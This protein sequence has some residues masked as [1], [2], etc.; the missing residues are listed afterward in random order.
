[1]SR[2][3]SPCPPRAYLLRG[4][5]G[6]VI[7]NENG[8]GATGNNS[9]VAYLGLRVKMRPSMFRRLARRLSGEQRRVGS[10]SYL[11]EQMA[12]GRGIGA[13]TLYLRIPD[14]WQAGDLSL[15]ASIASHEGRH[16]ML[17]AAEL[18][19]DEP[20]ETHVLP[21][22]YRRRHLTPQW[23]QRIQSGVISED[24]EYIPGPL[25]TSYL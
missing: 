16:R 14:D 2:R 5:S 19:G 25:F 24:G 1:M 21:V 15:P 7:D 12:A 10:S 4:L 11:R 13:P 22:H 3:C 18:F 9:N 8:I 20:V 23:L 6:V 17:T